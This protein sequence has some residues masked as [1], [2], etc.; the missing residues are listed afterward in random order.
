MFTRNIRLGIGIFAVLL[1]GGC[2]EPLGPNTPEDED[3]DTGK[4]QQQGFAPVTFE[5]PVLV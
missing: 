3:R 5:P 1:L 2:M 4:D